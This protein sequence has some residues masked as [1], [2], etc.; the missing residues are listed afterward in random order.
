MLEFEKTKAS[1]QLLKLNKTIY[2][3]Q[4][5]LPKGGWYDNAGDLYP[6]PYS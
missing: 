3:L 4:E 5:T 2:Q 6:I 1:N